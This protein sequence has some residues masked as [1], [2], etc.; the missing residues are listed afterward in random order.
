ML[1]TTLVLVL[2]VWGLLQI[3]LQ[4][5]MSTQ[6]KSALPI[7]ALGVI[8]LLWCLVWFGVISRATC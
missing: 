6:V 8:V 5:Q 3:F 7:I 1:F 4:I 2:I